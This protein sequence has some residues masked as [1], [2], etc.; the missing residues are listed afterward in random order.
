M[1]AEPAEKAVNKKLRF[2]VMQYNVLADFYHGI[3]RI[4]KLSAEFSLRFPRIKLELKTSNS[5]ILFL[6]EVDHMDM[7]VPLLHELGYKLIFAQR[8]TDKDCIVIAFKTSVFELLD[9]QIIDYND[10]A[11][12]G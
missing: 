10:L 11:I 2:K 8:K 4:Q 6:Q 1:L 7:Y 3:R 5:D 9:E 12:P